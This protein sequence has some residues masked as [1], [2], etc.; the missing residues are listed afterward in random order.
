MSMYYLC[1]TEVWRK[2]FSNCIKLS[3]PNDL[4]RYNRIGTLLFLTLLNLER[5]HPN[6]LVNF[7]EYDN[8][9][10]A[11]FRYSLIPMWFL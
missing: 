4:K 6:Y 10:A 7:E 2:K 3:Y 5:M 8:S 1:L 9:N 11:A